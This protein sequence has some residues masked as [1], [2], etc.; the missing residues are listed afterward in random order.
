MSEVNYKKM[1]VVE[2]KSQLEARNI[3]IP[4]G[5][6]KAELLALVLSSVEAESN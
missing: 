3:D 1:K 2:L 4:R 6:K 5:A